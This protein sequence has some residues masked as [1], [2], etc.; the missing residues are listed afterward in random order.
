M[1]QNRRTFLKLSGLGLLTFSVGGASLLLTPAQA[2]AKNVPLKVLTA[3]EAHILEILGETLH[4]GASEAG[5]A[6]FV[7]YQLSVK[8]DDCRSLVKYFVNDPPF[9]N[10][11]RAGIK[12]LQAY[13]KAKFGASFIDLKDA[14]RVALVKSIGRDSPKE[15]PFPPPAPL[16]YMVVR[17]DTADV[18][19]GTLDGFKRLGV[20]Y[21]PHIVPPERW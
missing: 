14:D 7:D 8:P 17:N 16:F 9:D 6:N 5:L 2:K 19:Y 3:D 4:P 18:L 11:Y 21:M 10:F 1:A 12:S 13:S 15:W 20:P